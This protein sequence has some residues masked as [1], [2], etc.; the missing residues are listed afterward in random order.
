[1]KVFL[2]PVRVY[3]EDTD[4][5]GVV[6]HANYLRFYERAR[7][8]MLRSLGYEQDQ[9]VSEEN[10]IFAVRSMRVEYKKPAKFNDLLQVSAGIA[11]FGSASLTFAQQIFRG[12]ELLSTAEARIA[13]L[14]ASKL[15]PTQIPEKL[16]VSFKN[17]H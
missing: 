6:Y 16:K 5:G 7:T 11:K 9:L 14:N 8:E 15:I 12:D 4:S 17:E 1:M 10:I 2:W 13:C 3:Y